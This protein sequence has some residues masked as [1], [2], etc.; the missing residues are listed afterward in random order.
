MKL[1]FCLAVPLLLA[2]PAFADV[3]FDQR[4][5]IQAGGAMSM[6]GSE[7]TSSTQISGN[8]AR[9]DSTIS[10][11]SALASCVSGS[12]KSGS[13]VRLDK[14]LTWELLPD[15]QQ[16]TE[17]TFA[18]VREQMAQAQ[19]AMK[20]SQ[21]SAGPGG[22]LPV[23]TESCKWSE[24]GTQVQQVGGVEK[25]AG[26]DTRKHVIRARQTCTDPETKSTC[27]ITW[28]MESWLGSNLPG[29]QQARQFQQAYATA[30]GLD[31]V[32]RQAQGPAQSLISMFSGNWK[33]VAAEVAKLQGFPLRT[34]MQMSI[35]G[36]HCTTASGEPIASDKT[37]SDSGTTG[38]SVGS[39]LGGSLG[40]AA[41]AA[42]GQ[43]LGGLSGMLGKKSSQPAA[44]QPTEKT[45]GQGA[46]GTPGEITV[47]RIST[48]TTRWNEAPV[49]AERFEVPAGWKRM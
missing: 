42:A 13:I 39:A 16:Y 40:G 12:G 44:A 27:D 37:W 43:L 30:M 45:A 32:M 5:T 48:E 11:K 25:V 1:R 35:G 46:A 4:F 15:K 10:M 22:P 49:P 38:E 26:L 47:F 18:Q 29:E 3:S 19:A 8:K 9:M 7:G 34:V 14:E 23:S 41:G 33:T 2:Y 28:L 20:E 21:G 24:G 31:E 6:L 17:L 36:E